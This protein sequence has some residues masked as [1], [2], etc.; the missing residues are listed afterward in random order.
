MGRETE[1]KFMVEAGSPGDV[2]DWA[3]KAGLMK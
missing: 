2:L 3:A 1:F